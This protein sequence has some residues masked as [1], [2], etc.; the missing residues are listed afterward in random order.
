MGK[1]ERLQNQS[2]LLGR[3]AD[4]GVAFGGLAQSLGVLQVLLLVSIPWHKCTSAACFTK[5][6]PEAVCAS[7]DC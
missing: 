6:P 2:A 7:S 4:F 3:K 5:S 1:T